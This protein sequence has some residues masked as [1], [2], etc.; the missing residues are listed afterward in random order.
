VDQVVVATPLPPP[1]SDLVLPPL[2]RPP[3]PTLHHSL[4]VRQPEGSVGG[5][6]QRHINAWKEIGADSYCLD[7][8]ENGYAPTFSTTWPPLTTAWQAHESVD[9]LHKREILQEQVTTLLLKN[10]IELVRLTRSSGFYSRV[11]LVRKKNGKMRPVIN[12]RA[13]NSYLVKP[14]FRMETVRGVCLSVQPGDWATSLDLTDGYFHVPI[15]P[16]FRK[17]LRFVINGKVYQFRAL[18][19]G[20]STAPLVFTRMLQPLAVYV[21]LRGHLLHRYLDDLL[22]RSQVRDAVMTNT[23]F[24]LDLLFRLGWRVNVDKSML[25]PSQ[26][27][28]YIGVRFLTL[29]G[30]MVPPDDRILKI[31]SAAQHLLQGPVTAKRFLSLLG[32]LGSAEKQVPTGR[33]HL[34][35]LQ[36]CLRAQFSMGVHQLSHLVSVANYPAAI[37]ALHWWSDRDNLMV[38]QPL[39]PFVGDHTLY[40]DASMT[41]WGAHDDTTTFQV[42]GVWSLQDKSQSINFLELKAVLLALRSAPLSWQSLKLLIAT[43]NSTVVAYINNQGGTRSML[44]LDLTSDLFRLAEERQL[45]LR[46][47]HIPGRL[48][49]FADLLSRPDQIVNT[50]WTLSMQAA[51]QLWSIWGRPHLDLMATHLTS[52]LPTFVSPFPHPQ[53]Y[54][55]DAMSLQWDRMD[56]Y[57]F[58][59]W[60]M[61]QEVL[62]KLS[63]ATACVFTLVVPRWPNRPW[64]PL[65]LDLLVDVPRKF[66]LYENLLS[67]PVNGRRHGSLHAIDLHACRVSSSQPL[68]VAFRE[69]CRSSCPLDIRGIPQFDSTPPDGSLSLFGVSN[70]IS[71]PSRPL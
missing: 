17:Y 5:C 26:D 1:R 41:Q 34:R 37:Q 15:A 47:R 28:V 66:P 3:L 36:V 59:P 31:F 56:A 46:A 16:S 20:L 44:L 57:V 27:F 33:L 30:V 52:R 24:L 21:H 39:G 6:L 18:P 67:M 2:S 4:V 35:P 42:S 22:P 61:I 9:S 63:L 14:S 40:T 62:V 25:V 43:D 54:A 50:E 49:R 64:F 48:N 29:L 13:L 11:F 70:G 32:L 12:L 55:V 53:A 45:T 8:L 65:L 38:G 7:I 10:A 58:P 71:I 60:S 19:F 69:K 23:Q 51:T 68:A